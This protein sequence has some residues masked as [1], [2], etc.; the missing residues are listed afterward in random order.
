[1]ADSFVFQVDWTT[2][3]MVIGAVASVIVALFYA[4]GVKL[5]G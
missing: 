5:V 1:M 2:V 4:R 3:A